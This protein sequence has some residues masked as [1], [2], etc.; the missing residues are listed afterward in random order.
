MENRC[1]HCGAP[2]PL[3]SEFCFDC[4][5][6]ASRTKR[7]PWD[8]GDRTNAGKN[9]SEKAWQSDQARQRQHE[10]RHTSHSTSREASRDYEKAQ[11]TYQTIRTPAQ[12]KSGAQTKKS[13]K[14]KPSAHSVRT[15]RGKSV[16][17]APILACIALVLFLAEGFGGS[18]GASSPQPEPASEY[19]YY[20]Y[21]ATEEQPD[22]T[23]VEEWYDSDDV[24]VEEN[25]FDASGNLVQ[26]N[27]YLDGEISLAEYYD[28]DGIVSLQEW[29]EDG[30]LEHT[31]IFDDGMLTMEEYFDEDG[32]LTHMET[33]TYDENWNLTCDQVWDGQGNLLEGF[34]YTYYENWPA[35]SSEKH[36]DSSGL[37]TDEWY[38]NQNGETIGA[39]NRAEDGTVSDAWGVDLEGNDL[40]ELL[41]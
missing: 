35:C 32:L 26:T 19:S 24:L 31:E 12:P 37:V 23:Q 36:I 8:Q 3:G 33:Y 5:A 9:T 11:H 25:F 1:P 21:S 41:N 14:P 39:V 7:D 38:Y 34:E 13:A 28:M 22:G 40:T 20:A 15:S 2:L 16:G 27:V 29:Y 30:I 6:R 18:G 10:R 17:L 4:G